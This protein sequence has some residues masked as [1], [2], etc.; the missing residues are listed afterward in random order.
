M[1]NLELL[2]CKVLYRERTEGLKKPYSFEWDTE[3]RM[4]FWE[5]QLVGFS[6]KWQT[7]LERVHPC[8]TKCHERFG[9]NALLVF[10]FMLDGALPYIALE[11]KT[12]LLEIHWRQ[13][14]KLRIKIEWPLWS[15]DMT[16]RDFL[17]W[18][19]LKCHV[20]QGSL[21]TLVELK[22]SISWPVGSTDCDIQYSPATD[23]VTSL[24]CLL[25]CVGGHAG[26]LSL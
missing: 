3:V 5:K 18:G 9:K 1:L 17:L 19:Y 25:S 8:C 22:D 7:I 21:T 15:P 11:I 16:Q 14:D 13:S 20:Y 26:Y 4:T 23:V 24:T 10:I 2:H 6:M 12:F